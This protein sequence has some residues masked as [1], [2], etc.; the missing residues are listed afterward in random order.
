MSSGLP[1]GASH[2]H[3]TG[4]FCEQCN[5]YTP[6]AEE[7]LTKA[8]GTTP[9]LIAHIPHPSLKLNF[10]CPSKI[11]VDQ[12]VNRNKRLAAQ[13]EASSQ[14][15]LYNDFVKRQI[16]RSRYIPEDL[17]LM[18]PGQFLDPACSVIPRL[19]AKMWAPPAE[20]PSPSPRLPRVASSISLRGSH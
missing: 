15:A 19:I 7:K 16:I 9:P 18:V 14:T 6:T 1:V 12:V 5:I 17:V 11:E 13:I 3:W 4:E 20:P 10:A 2:I 8:A